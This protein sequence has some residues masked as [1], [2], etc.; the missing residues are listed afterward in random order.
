MTLPSGIQV[1]KMDSIYILGGDVILSQAQID[2]LSRPNTR[3][4]HICDWTKVW[5]KG[6]V[7]YS[8]LG[9]EN[10]TK[11]EGAIA[12]WE[13]NTNIRF[14]KTIYENPDYVEFISDQGNWSK[15]GQIGGKQ[16]ISLYP[17]HR[18]DKGSAIHEIGHT[19]GLFHEQCRL[20]RDNYITINWNNIIEKHKHN[21]KTYFQLGYSS[22][23]D[24][25]PFDFNSIMLYS[26]KNSFAIDINE[27]T[28]TKKDGSIFSGQQ[29]HL[30]AGDIAAINSQYPIAYNDEILYLRYDGDVKNV[31]APGGIPCGTESTGHYVFISKH[32]VTKDTIIDLTIWNQETSRDYEDITWANSDRV[33]IPKGDRYVTYSIM[34][35]YYY[36]DKAGWKNIDCSLHTDKSILYIQN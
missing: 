31:Y 14:W 16:Q 36:S 20:D 32:P 33:I 29:S 17:D 15:L 13:A 22:G 24:I 8:I 30:S 9:V 6:I 10:K 2:S 23:K 28:M 18:S 26:S 35:N 5:S 1:E 11:I 21:Y 27:P 25:G 19:L 34:E 4:A 12:H 7:F 3:A